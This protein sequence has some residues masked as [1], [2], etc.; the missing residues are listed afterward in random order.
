MPVHVTSEYGKLRKVMLHRPAQELNQLT[1]G[2]MEE[3][4]FGDLPFLNEA[5]REHDQYADMLRACGAEVLYMEDLAAETLKKNPSV[6]EQFLDDFICQG[7]PIAQKHRQQLKNFF[8]ELED[9]REIVR[10]AIS[11]VRYEECEKSGKRSLYEQLGG[12]SRY[13]LDPLPNMYFVRDLMVPVGERVCLTSMKSRTRMRESIFG[14][15]IMEHHPDFAGTDFCYRENDLYYIE[16]GDILNLS[17]RVIAVGLSQRT[18]PEAIEL[19]AKRLFA[20]PRCDVETVLAL[21][22]PHVR[23]YAH[24]DAVIT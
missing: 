20:D 13:L 18:T 11:G 19:L 9:E 6:K 22:V 24:L 1:P 4:L 15:Y 7:G 12:Y 21:D 2:R 17:N 10:K 23:S 14:A 8:L 16:G 3:L 5:Q